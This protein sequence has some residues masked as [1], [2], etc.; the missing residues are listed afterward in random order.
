MTPYKVG[1][2]VYLNEETIGDTQGWDP[3][4]RECLNID[5]VIGAYNGDSEEPRYSHVGNRRDTFPWAHKELLPTDPP[6]FEL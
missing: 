4:Y 5:F 3:C 2:V 1:D 6:L